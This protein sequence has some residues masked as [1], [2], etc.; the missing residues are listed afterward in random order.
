MFDGMFD[1][2]WNSNT[3][4]RGMVHEI[5]AELGGVIRGMFDGM[6]GGTFDGMLMV[7]AVLRCFPFQARRMLS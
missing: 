1:E 2:A 6:F 7:P 3:M 5:A 4:L